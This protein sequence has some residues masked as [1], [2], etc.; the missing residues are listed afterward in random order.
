MRYAA[1]L[2]TANACCDCLHARA[3]THTHTHA[4]PCVAFCFVRGQDPSG[5]NLEFKAMSEP[6]N[7]FIKYHVADSP[8]E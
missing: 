2:M 3:R 6:A 8:K 5:N 4:F 1:C 7:L